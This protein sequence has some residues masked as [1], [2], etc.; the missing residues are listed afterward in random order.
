MAADE[1]IAQRAKRTGLGLI[2]PLAGLSGLYA[3]MTS[4]ADP[5]AAA[6]LVAAVPVDWQVLLRASKG[7]VPNF[8]ADME[9]PAQQQL[10]APAAV[11]GS[12][13]SGAAAAAR[14]RKA[15]RSAR[16]AARAAGRRQVAADEQ[17][18]SQVAA[19]SGEAVQ[20]AVLDVT[21]SILGAEVAPGQPL[22]DA[23]LDSL[24]EPAAAVAA[25]AAVC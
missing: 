10:E 5:Y 2:D 15:H 9:A 12:R 16:G 24:G 17:E 4:L 6:A 22:M 20:A 11:G 23:G 14:H 13:K 19:V 25:A 21:R 1:A 18:K 7:S 3:I 8:F